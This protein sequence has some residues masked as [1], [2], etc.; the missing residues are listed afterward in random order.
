MERAGG[1]AGAQRLQPPA[2]LRH[3]KEEAASI[4]ERFPLGVIQQQ[5]DWLPYRHAKSPARFLVA[6]IEGNYEAPHIV[7]QSERAADVDDQE[8]PPTDAGVQKTNRKDRSLSP[9]RAWIYHY[10]FFN[11]GST[12]RPL[13]AWPTPPAVRGLH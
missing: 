1:R 7:H 10:H 13:A 4:L 6:A 11:S 12:R 3:S 9:S 5:L 8:E 2:E